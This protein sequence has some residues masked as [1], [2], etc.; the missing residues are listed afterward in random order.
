M[1]LF[2]IKYENQPLKMCLAGSI[3]EI[4]TVCHKKFNLNKDVE[5]KI[6]LEDGTE[7]DDNEVLMELTKRNT[8]V[9]VLKLYNENVENLENTPHRI[10]QDCLEGKNLKSR[11]KTLIASTIATLM[12]ETNNKSLNVA[13]QFAEK[14][15]E[16]HPKTF[17]DSVGGVVWGDGVH[18]LKQQIY[19]KIGYRKKDEEKKR[20]NPTNEDSDDEGVKNRE[21]EAER[22]KRQDE[23]GCINFAPALPEITV[24]MI[25]K[26][27]VLSS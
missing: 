8:D 27:H 6:A 12:M 15:C 18:T 21:K 5:Y 26:Q 1:T 23:H 10:H 24:Q 11:D 25:K 9:I 22:N 7:I 2:K 20:K 13:L 4:M 14:L 3:E 19:N 17:E 16:D